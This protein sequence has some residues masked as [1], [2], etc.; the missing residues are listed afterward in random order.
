MSA[1]F[2]I[3]ICDLQTI[4]GSCQ[5][6]LDVGPPTAPPVGQLQY[7]YC[8]VR[9]TGTEFVVVLSVAMTMMFE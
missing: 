9:V 7:L 4:R 1:A 5:P 2:T 6:D 8:T 3:E